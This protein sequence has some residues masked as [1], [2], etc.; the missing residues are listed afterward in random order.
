MSL[1]F[2]YSDDY[3]NT[4]QIRDNFTCDKSEAYL[5]TPLISATGY[6][7]TGPTLDHNVD[8]VIESASDLIITTR[9]SINGR[10]CL[11]LANNATYG[12]IAAISGFVSNGSVESE[13]GFNVHCSVNG[14]SWTDQNQ[15][16]YPQWY[17]MNSDSSSMNAAHVMNLTTNIPIFS[18]SDYQYAYDY[19]AAESSLTRLAALEHAINYV[20][21]EY[22]VD[23]TK[24]YF[25]YNHYGTFHVKD[26]AASG[27]A[28]TW[29]S[30]VFKANTRPAFYFDDNTFELKLV[31][32]NVVSSYYL[33]SPGYI[34]DVL[35]V[36]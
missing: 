13:V 5:N 10:Y 36:V 19:L 30:L 21:V 34:M 16:Q 28:N 3:H 29:A 24:T 33:P 2:N 8:F 35:T 4:L 27:S 18:H 23:E 14:T 20:D 17:L 15:S 11:I 6:N 26:G 22:D 32:P 12:D 7:T 1:P 25:A 31:A 9:S